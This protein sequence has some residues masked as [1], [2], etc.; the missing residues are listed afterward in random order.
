MNVQTQPIYW[1]AYTPPATHVAALVQQ[2]LHMISADK[3]VVA[4]MRDWRDARRNSA[5]RVRP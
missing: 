2:P 3:L 4:Y 1:N 5:V